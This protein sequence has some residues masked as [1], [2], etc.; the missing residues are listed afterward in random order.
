[1]ILEQASRALAQ[2]IGQQPVEMQRHRSTQVLDHVQ[3]QVIIA[4]EQAVLE[5]TLQHWA[6]Q[7]RPRDMN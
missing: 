6:L 5:H 2:S 1:M 7:F 4:M 3:Q